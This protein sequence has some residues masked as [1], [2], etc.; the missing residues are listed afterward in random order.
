MI[1]NRS[2]SLH[3]NHFIYVKSTF[4]CNLNNNN[5]RVFVGICQFLFFNETLGEILTKAALQLDAGFQWLTLYSLNSWNYDGLVIQ[6]L[7]AT[8]HRNLREG[9]NFDVKNLKI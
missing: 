1:R 3:K 6:I 5:S 8:M 7:D 9:L 4:E 2:S